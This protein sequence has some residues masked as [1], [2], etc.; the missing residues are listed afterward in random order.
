MVLGVLKDTIQKAAVA[1][2]SIVTQVAVKQRFTSEGEPETVR[3]RA[4]DQALN[5]AS[6][7]F[8]GQSAQAFARAGARYLPKIGVGRIVHSLSKRPVAAAGVALF[9]V[10]AVRDGLHY[11]QGSI[12]GQEL[13]ERTS[14]HAFGLASSAGGAAVGAAI[15]SAIMPL[16]GTAVGG[17]VGGMVA[18]AGGTAAGRSVARSVVRRVRP[19]KQE[20]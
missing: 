20:D 18:G 13:A 3:K 1:T 2:A 8:V 6:K 16:I 14:G 5:A 15:G 12:D 7:M 9:A 10:D 11:S 4:R 17:I 19:A